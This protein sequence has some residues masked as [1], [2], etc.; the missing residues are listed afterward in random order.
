MKPQALAR[1]LLATLVGFCAMVAAAGTAAQ[2]AAARNSTAAE[3]RLD[4]IVRFVRKPA[5]ACD[6]LGDPGQL[7]LF[8][9]GMDTG[10]R[11]LGCSDGPQPAISFWFRPT[12]NAHLTPEAREA[13]WQVIL[14]NALATIPNGRR[15]D[16]DIV[17]VDDTT[18]TTQ[19]LAP[20]VHTLAFHIFD[21]TAWVALG[22][23]LLV[24]V[25]L[26]WLARRSGLLRDPA[27]TSMQLKHRS[28]S[29][30]RTQL[31]WWFSIIFA[32]FVFLWLV[33]GEAPALSGQA[34]A[35]LGISGVTTLASAG[36]SAG[37]TLPSA[38]PG[39][40]FRDLLSDA[41][42]IT[43][44]RF[45]MLVMTMALGIVFLIQVATRLTM[46]AF[47]ASLLT[48]LGISAGTYVGLKIPEKQA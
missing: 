41:N 26:V 10:L 18:H 14:G 31:A 22:A 1:R 23:V 36:I 17:L 29:L 47:D 39:R 16:Y 13:V 11:G 19:H 6:A 5:P 21:A 3:V 8:I 7:R 38:E 25:L 30:A 4:E 2:P 44:Q 45:Q 9:E 28:F 15:L 34:L 35:F 27:N 20:A 24:G 37:E 42:G 43:I 32:T 33:T 46:P 40:F 12:A 48:L